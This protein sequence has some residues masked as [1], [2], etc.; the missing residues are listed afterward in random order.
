M[1]TGALRIGPETREPLS[2]WGGGAHPTSIALAIGEEGED[3]RE[4]PAERTWGRPPRLLQPGFYF[5]RRSF[6][7]NACVS[8][9]FSAFVLA[10]SARSWW[11][12][13][14]CCS[15]VVSRVRR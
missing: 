13:P 14:S 1:K 7:R 15:M 2:P 3:G 6:T 4:G 10:I 11:K 12:I 9:V 5:T 8:D